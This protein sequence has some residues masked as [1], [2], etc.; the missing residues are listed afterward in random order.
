METRESFVQLHLHYE[1]TLKIVPCNITLKLALAWYFEP[2]PLVTT[3]RKSWKIIPNG[4]IENISIKNIRKERTSNFG[5][6]GFRHVDLS[7][8]YRDLFVSTWDDTRLYTISRFLQCEIHHPV[9][10]AWTAIS[11]SFLLMTWNFHL[12]S[13]RNRVSDKISWLWSCRGPDGSA[14]SWGRSRVIFSLP[15]FK[16]HYWLVFFGACIA[17]FCG[18]LPL[19]LVYKAKIYQQSARKEC[20]FTRLTWTEDWKVAWVE[21]SCRNKDT[22][23]WI[24]FQTKCQLQVK[25]WT[26]LALC[27]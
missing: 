12:F 23:S 19:I 6:L 13:V 7:L 11:S 3:F 9:H 14:S 26:I 18:S 21:L 27:S 4:T 2:T 24:T 8:S 17:C 10:N 20:L 16:V 25:G 15:L 1:S 22:T 5:L